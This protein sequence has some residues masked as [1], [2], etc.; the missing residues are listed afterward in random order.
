M[1]IQKSK[2]CTSQGSTRLTFRKSHTFLNGF[3][4]LLTDFDGK[5][6]RGAIVSAVLTRYDKQMLKV[7]HA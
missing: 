5:L 1:V 3:T 6:A 4:C 7:S 2:L